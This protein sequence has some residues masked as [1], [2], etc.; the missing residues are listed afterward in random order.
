MIVSI[1]GYTPNMPEAGSQW[2]KGSR[3]L[4]YC[5]KGIVSVG[6]S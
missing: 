5:T 6:P 2:G 4:V 3:M 1:R